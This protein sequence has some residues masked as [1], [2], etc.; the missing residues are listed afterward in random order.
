MTL[1]FDAAVTIL[2]ILFQTVVRPA[3]PFLTGIYSPLIPF[4]VYLALF[5]SGREAVPLTLCVGFLMDSLSAGPFGIYL[6]TYLWLF[7]SIKWMVGYLRVSN[8][9]LLPLVVVAGVLIENLV[10][11]GTIL[12]LMPGSRLPEGT[13]VRV[14][15][16]L[17][18]AF[19]T[20][21]I[22]LALLDHLWKKW[23]GW[24][25]VRVMPDRVDEI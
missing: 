17:L 14:S 25:T 23:S 8:T 15:Q 20:G 5:R 4:V 24:V 18:W 6:T 21:M 1:L 7:L 9:L 3:I 13:A 2:L 12:F 22:P 10:F 11:L 19:L 16:Q